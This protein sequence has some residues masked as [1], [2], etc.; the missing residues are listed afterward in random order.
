MT[1]ILTREDVISV[2]EMKDCMNAVEKA[3]IELIN[4]TAVLPLRIGIT[5]PDGLAL[6]MPAYLKEMKALA[7]KVVTVYKNNPSKC[8]SEIP[9]Y[10]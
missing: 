3:F 2:L 1:L 6:Y 5:P 10:W 4:G 9:G 7:C 8:R